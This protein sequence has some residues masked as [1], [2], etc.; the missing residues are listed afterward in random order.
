MLCPV[1]DVTLQIEL[2][3]GEYLAED[4]WNNDMTWNCVIWKIYKSN[5]EFFWPEKG[6]TSRNVITVIKSLKGYDMKDLVLK[7]PERQNYNLWIETG[8]I[9]IL[10][11]YRIR[12]LTMLSWKKGD[13]A[14]KEGI[15][16]SQHHSHL[17]TR[18]VTIR[19]SC[20]MAGTTLCEKRS[21]K[22]FNVQFWDALMNLSFM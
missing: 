10:S 5:R 3:L 11:P 12:F 21:H 20:Y 13:L 14:E 15:R 7:G 2:S 18:M 8:G 22:P 9:Q 6:K 1:T 4:I 17:N 16:L 19:P